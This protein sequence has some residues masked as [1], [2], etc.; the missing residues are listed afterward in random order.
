MPAMPIV[1]NGDVT[2]FVSWGMDA[3]ALD[4]A[5]RCLRWPARPARLVAA[6]A[7]G[8]GPTLLALLGY[9]VP[10]GAA[11]LLAPLAMG[12]TAWVPLPR[13]TYWRGILW[14]AG[15]MV[16]AGGLVTALT[17]VGVPVV[18]ALLAAPAA[19]LGVRARW[20]R[21]VAQPLA[22]RRGLARVRCLIGGQTVNVTALWDTGNRLRDP[23]AGRPVM[24]VTWD[25]IAAG[26]DPEAK[27]F[28]RTVLDGH[29]T[30][31]AAGG[32]RISVMGVTTATGRRLLPV[33]V[34]DRAELEVEGQWRVLKP[35]VMAVTDT[36]L[37]TDD[38]YQALLHPEVAAGV[39]SE[40]A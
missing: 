21:E 1:V 37:S 9:A 6:A 25:R 11:A 29:P 36:P 40:G 39:L 15:W 24:V 20:A 26:L 31:V 4:L 30:A 12:V 14:L 13:R 23:I 33:V 19:L 27:R 8:S 38:T 2:L 5:S 35:L 17:D 7:I 18:P 10:A 34:P 32:H 3:M 28:L 16:V 22:A